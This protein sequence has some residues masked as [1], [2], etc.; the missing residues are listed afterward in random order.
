MIFSV[1]KL[2]ACYAPFMRVAQENKASA[3][4]VPPK[5]SGPDPFSPEAR[6]RRQRLIA[7]INV[8]H[9]KEAKEAEGAL[10]DYLDTLYPENAVSH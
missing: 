2:E 4:V 8:S 7:A 9:S 6:T 5:V 1:E 10:S 3:G